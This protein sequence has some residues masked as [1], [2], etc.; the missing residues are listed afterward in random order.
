MTRKLK[1]YTFEQARD[2]VTD[3]VLGSKKRHERWR[4]L[5]ALYRTGSISQAEQQVV[6]GKIGEFF[7]D[8]TDE[9]VNLVLPHLNII[10]ASVIARDPQLVAVPYGGGE[11]AEAHRD[12][13]EG[14]LNYFWSRLQTTRE[15]RDATQDAVFLGSGFMKTGW[16]TVVGDEE[17]RHEGDVLEDALAFAE[18][19]RLLADL[20]GD[21]G[22]LP[23]LEEAV[24][25]VPHSSRQ[26][27]RDEPFTEYT[28]PY[29]LFVPADCRRI[30]DARW[31]AHRVSLPL[32]EVLANPAYSVTEEDL[33]TDG[34]SGGSHDEFVA[35]SARQ[36][37]ED[38][39]VYSNAT[40][41]EMVTLYE[42]YDMRTRKLTIFQ[43]DGTEPIFEDEFAWF[44]QLPP[45]VH[46]RNYRQSGNDFWGFGDLENIATAQS[47]YNEML[48]EQVG[49]AR[50]AGNKS[51]I[52]KDLFSAE[53]KSVLESS[54]GDAV[55]VVNLPPG[56]DLRTVV[57]P[58]ERRPLPEEQF[59]LKA[60]MGEAVKTTLGINDFQAGG[61]G[62]DRMSAT[63]AA[64]VDGVATLRAQDKIGS[65]E[66]AASAV[67]TRML[68]LCQQFLDAPTAIRVA[69]VE[70]ANW[71]DVS[72]DDIVG[73]FMVSVEGGST[74]AINPQTREAQG[75][76]TLGEVLPA[77]VQLGYSHK[78]ALRQALRDLGYDP[79]VLLVA[80]EQ[81]EPGP[82]SENGGGPP[83]AERDPFAEQAEA[84]A[85]PSNGE[86]MMEMGGPPMPADA[87]AA[88]RVLL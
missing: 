29:D 35:E 79:D 73:E 69:G 42:F 75:L 72:Q 60:E 67:S 13:V 45:F 66:D 70:K 28:S 10:L 88:G 61:S 41:T 8:L 46:V 11:A 86:Q 55:G 64:V 84:E 56:E 22:F 24:E 31:I 20:E 53:L 21:D 49:S 44:H 40:A 1:A 80:P 2:L 74:K 78:P 54:E 9:V 52:R 32:D 50:R 16:I 63:A 17:D 27:L 38:E 19:E 7:P 81:P 12:T 26:T 43:H 58:I 37:Y 30:E 39:G 68:L 5:E 87:Q 85:G 4:L 83:P 18:G 33:K 36:A 77:L 15:L 62:A 3:A 25:H 14:V 71:I 34:A 82:G 23:D 47:L 76:R 57:M 59:H 48:S 6:P 51:I 65:V